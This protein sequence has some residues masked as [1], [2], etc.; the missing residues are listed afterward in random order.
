MGEVVPGTNPVAYSGRY[1]DHHVQFVRA[2][3][4]YR[5]RFAATDAK[6]RRC[7]SYLG[8]CQCGRAAGG[9]ARRRRSGRQSRWPVRAPQWRRALLSDAVV[10]PFQEWTMQHAPDNKLVP[11]ANVS[12]PHL[13]E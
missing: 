8:H 5:V 1:P 11:N 3:S 10:L 4:T 13:G 7:E 9:S 6:K 2:N 12:F